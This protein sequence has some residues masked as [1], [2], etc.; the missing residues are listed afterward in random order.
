MTMSWK[1]CRGFLECVCVLL[2]SC[3][4]SSDTQ[5]REG[6]EVALWDHGDKRT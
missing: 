2:G 6:G 3:V 5:K 1:R 4:H